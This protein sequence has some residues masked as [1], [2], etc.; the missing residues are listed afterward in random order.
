MNE[1]SRKVLEQSLLIGGIRHKHQQTTDYIRHRTQNR[2]WMYNRHK[3]TTSTQRNQH[4]AHMGTPPT[5]RITDKTKITTTHTPTTLH[6]ITTQQTTLRRKK[7]TIYN[8]TDYTTDIDTNPKTID[9]AKIKT[10]IKHIHITIV[11][12]YLNNRQHNKVTNTIPLTVHHSE[13]TL[14]RATR[15][16]LTQLRTN[17]CPLLRSYLNKIDKVQQTP[18]LLCPLSTSEPHTTT[19]LFNCGNIDTQL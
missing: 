2:N 14:P 6:Y 5:T 17:K 3:H 15:R 9:D 11:S 13:T 7:Q 4:F 19:H 10:T 8:N 18:I 1:R 16:N 12:T